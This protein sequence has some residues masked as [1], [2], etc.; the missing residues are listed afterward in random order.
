M[1]LIRIAIEKKALDITSEARTDYIVV[2]ADKK[3]KRCLIGGAIL[4]ASNCIALK[5]PAFD[6]GNWSNLF[7]Y[8]SNLIKC[9]CNLLVRM[10]PFIWST[11]VIFFLVYQVWLEL[12]LKW[13]PWPWKR[14][15]KE[16]L[17][18]CL[19]TDA[20]VDNCYHVLIVFL[21]IVVLGASGTVCM[22][23]D[24]KYFVG[25]QISYISF[26]SNTQNKD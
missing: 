7:K 19:F 25:K 12:F 24:V 3:C 18:L 8:M 16:C 23:F 22:G 5:V 15:T 11:P 9:T 1:L 6:V 2:P 17:L 4:I 10:W 21:F 20:M 26:R 13:P 14:C